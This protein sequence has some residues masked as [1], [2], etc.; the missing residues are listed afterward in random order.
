MIVGDSGP[1]RCG[2]SPL[3][4]G[5]LIIDEAHRL[6]MPE[7]EEIRDRYDRANFAGRVGVVQISLPGIEKRLVPSPQH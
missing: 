5:L 1:Y 6:K 3:V 4:A 2:R 7:L